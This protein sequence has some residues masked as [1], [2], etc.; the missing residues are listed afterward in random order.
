MT[1]SAPRTQL[2]ASVQSANRILRRSSTPATGYPQAPPRH[3]PS[4]TQPCAPGCGFDTDDDQ[5][6][7]ALQRIEAHHPKVDRNVWARGL[8][9]SCADAP[10]AEPAEG[11]EFAGCDSD[12]EKEPLRGKIVARMN[13]ITWPSEST[14]DVDGFLD[15]RQRRFE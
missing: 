13:P 12:R 1:S 6:R 7:F 4:R 3:S 11:N 9:C 2:V 14:S 15:S 5:A 10:I 8:R